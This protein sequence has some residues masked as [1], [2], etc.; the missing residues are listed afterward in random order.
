MKYM[1]VKTFDELENLGYYLTYDDFIVDE[2]DEIFLNPNQVKYIG[3]VGKVIG[4]T[5]IK[6]LLEFDGNEEAFPSNFVT[7]VNEVKANKQ[8][9]LDSNTL[10]EDAIRLKKLLNEFKEKGYEIYTDG[11]TV[12]LELNES[13]I[14][15]KL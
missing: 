10:L 5:G 14:Y 2:D 1:R 8:L 6:T 4:D 13:A 15:L 12:N 7:E 11:K 9:I 3:R